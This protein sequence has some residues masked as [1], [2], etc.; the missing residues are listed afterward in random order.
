MDIAD[1]A[2]PNIQQNEARS[3]SVALQPPA[4]IQPG[5]ASAIEC[6]HCNEPI[7]QARREALPGVQLCVDC[8]NRIERGAFGSD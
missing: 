7:P 5:I 1:R 2:D 8:A 4:S 6:R 3:L